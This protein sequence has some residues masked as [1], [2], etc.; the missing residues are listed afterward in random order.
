MGESVFR[1]HVYAMYN[2][3]YYILF[4]YS[5][6]FSWYSVIIVRNNHHNQL[7]WRYITCYVSSG[8][9]THDICPSTNSYLIHFFSFILIIWILLESGPRFHHVNAG[10]H[11]LD[12]PVA[13]RIIIE[14]VSF[15][16]LQTMWKECYCLRHD[17][18]LLW[19]FMVSSHW[20]CYAINASFR[21]IQN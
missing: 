18:L 19:I 17:L 16:I 4:F 12:V 6:F 13:K 14:L 15:D 9:S 7:I 1:L 2:R 8:S 20:Y 3:M 5:F 21:K 11:S 10:Y